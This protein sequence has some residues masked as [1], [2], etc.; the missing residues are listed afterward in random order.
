MLAACA[1]VPGGVS[2]LQTPGSQAV[3][4]P[5]QKP[6]SATS[7]EFDQPEEEMMVSTGVIGTG[8]FTEFQ[9]GALRIQLFS[10]QDEEV[11][12]VPQIEVSGKAPVGT[13]ISIN[14]QIIVVS[15]NGD[16]SVPVLLEEGPNV[17]ELVAS[18]LDGNEL[19]IMLTVVYEP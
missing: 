15:G 17:I 14:D 13:V 7:I 3:D 19:D 12:D 11:F 9:Q 18:D 1:P 5:T 8:V 16:F 4:V 2:E 10:P 6:E